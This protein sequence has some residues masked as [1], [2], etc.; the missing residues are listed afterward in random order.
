LNQRKLYIHGFRIIYHKTTM[1]NCWATI[2]MVNYCNFN[3]TLK[4]TLYSL[5]NLTVYLKKLTIIMVID[6]QLMFEYVPDKFY[7]Y[8]KLM[9]CPH[10]FINLTLQVI[11]YGYL[12]KLSRT[13]WISY[14]SYELNY[15][16]ERNNGK[17]LTYFDLHLFNQY[18]TLDGHNVNLYLKSFNI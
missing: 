17:L 14:W 4:C 5:P 8:L 13:I 10:C 2:V 16:I 6:K 7:I 9:D 3:I 11:F 1:N 18:I 12:Q 15:K